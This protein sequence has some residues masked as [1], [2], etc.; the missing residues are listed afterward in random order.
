MEKKS[1]FIT[2]ANGAIGLATVKALAERG[3][4][5]IVMAA[6]TE[7]KANEAR[8]ELL[9]TIEATTKIETAGGFDMH[10]PDAISS[11]VAA[12]PK[13]Q[14]FDVVFLQ[15]GGATFS[16]DYQYVEYGG[17]RIEQTTFQNAV[18]GYFT[19]TQLLANGLLA[20]DA[21]VVFMGGE[22]A[23]GVPGMNERPAFATPEDYRQYLTGEGSQR[24]YEPMYPMGVSK[25]SSALLVQ[26]LAQRDDGRTYVWFS[27]G[28]THGTKGFAKGPALK[29]FFIE[30]VMLK[31]TR[32]LG[33]SQST[34]KG[35]QR[36]AD[37]LLGKVGSNG[38]ILGTPKG[39]LLG[40]AT[41]QKPFNPTFTQ[42]PLIDEFWAIL[43]SI[44]AM[45]S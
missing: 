1:V 5:R 3:V 11:A 26:K 9:S 34:D 4:G 30:K 25:L 28:L 21:R 6:R 41:D 17:V 42:Q 39:K 37:C 7:R 13:G 16:D 43:Q 14:P 22:N 36:C 29:R 2:G 19:L 12:L 18:G 27:P 20:A 44:H 15:A 24:K 31:I 40:V 35:G 32:L 10:K 33:M 38:D 45:P 23:R 8:N